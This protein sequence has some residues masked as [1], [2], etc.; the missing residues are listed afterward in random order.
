MPYGRLPNLSLLQLV[1]VGFVLVML[2]LGLLVY[3]AS[4]TYR[5]LSAQAGL[6]A[7][8]AVAF[9]RRAQTLSSLA[10]EMERTTRQHKVM[11]TPALLDLIKNQQ[12]SFVRLLE[13]EFILFPPLAAKKELKALLMWMNTLPAD[14]IDPLEQLSA[15]T[16]QMEIETREAVDQHLGEFEQEVKQLQQQLAWQLLLLA[17]LSLVLI[18]FF[19]WRLLRPI[20]YLERRIAS[21]ASLHSPSEFKQLK[22]GPSELIK[23]DQRLNWLEK[24]LHEI[25]SQKQQFLRHI[26]HELKTPLASIREAADLLSEQLLGEL[27]PEQQEVA[28]LLEQNSRALQ[29]LIEQLLSYNQL[30]QNKAQT[31]TAIQLDPLLDEILATYR[32]QFQQQQQQIERHNTQIQLHTDPQLLGKVLDNLVSNAL[33]YGDPHQPLILRAGKSEESQ[34]I[35]VENSGPEIPENEQ[36]HLFEPFYQGSLRRKGSIKGSGI[37]LSIAADCMKT[38]KGELRLMYSRH[39]RTCFRLQWPRPNETFSLE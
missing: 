2:P 6:S 34:W 11:Q 1:L 13:Q 30:Q 24:Q 10:L 5:E 27:N 26:S 8:E 22:R 15:L 37:G 16:S 29:K 38:L 39:R 9:T 21:L 36:Q 14:K 4:N 23:L 20:G 31:S 12:E 28:Q 32:L 25:E 33:H 17:A 35:E 7:Q 19:T 18:L 3:Q